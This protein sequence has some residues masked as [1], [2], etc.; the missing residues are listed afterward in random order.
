MEW[1]PTEKRAPTVGLTSSPDPRT[2]PR[3]RRRPCR[4]R[5]LPKRCKVNNALVLL[6]PC[7]HW[8][9]AKL[10]GR[11]T[12]EASMHVSMLAQVRYGRQDGMLLLLTL[13]EV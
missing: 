12:L 4:H 11:G 9:K 3:K 10:V 1:T 2:R 8:S 6:A 5:T 13:L 7:S